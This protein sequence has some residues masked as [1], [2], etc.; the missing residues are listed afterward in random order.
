ME[1]LKTKIQT[2]QKKLKSIRSNSVISQLD[3]EITYINNKVWIENLVLIFI[4]F[5][6]EYNFTTAF[7]QIQFLSALCELEVSETINSSLNYSNLLKTLNALCQCHCDIKLDLSVI[8]NKINYTKMVQDLIDKLVVINEY[9]TALIVANIESVTVDKIIIEEYTYKFNQSPT[10]LIWN[11]CS[12]VFKS[13]Q[14]QPEKVISFF[15]ECSI[16]VNNFCDKYKILRIA[17]EWAVQFDHPEKDDLEKQMWC[18]FLEVEDKCSINLSTTESLKVLYK[19]MQDE[20]ECL[21]E[22][23]EELPEKDVVKLD[24]SISILLKNNCFWEALRIEKLFGHKNADLEILRLCCSIAEAILLPSELN[25]EQRIML[26]S[27][28][29]SR[30]YSQRRI[31]FRSTRQSSTSSGKYQFSVDL[32]LEMKIFEFK[33]KYSF[34]SPFAVYFNYVCTYINLISMFTE[35]IFCLQLCISLQHFVT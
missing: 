2:F 22:N 17:Y 20:L 4:A 30:G 18:T 34:L 35:K 28:R 19:D 11:D 25:A 26:S 7:D 27:S 32:I 15:Q 33:T 3:Q 13:H 12:K 1:I 6:L 8:Y 5:T 10:E 16:A 21:E 24:Q 23:S 29:S 31:P 9:K 14:V